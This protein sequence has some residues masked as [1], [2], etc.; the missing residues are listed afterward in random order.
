M[1][2]ITT[3]KRVEVLAPT[4][5]NH[6][7]LAVPES[8]TDIRP[9]IAADVLP[10]EAADAVKEASFRGE[11][12]AIQGIATALYG[13]HALREAGLS[14]FDARRILGEAHEASRSRLRGQLLRFLGPR[15]LEAMPDKLPAIDYVMFY[16]V[17]LNKRVSWTL[18][19]L[20]QTGVVYAQVT[21]DQ[22]AA[23]GLQVAT[24]LAQSGRTVTGAP[25][26][27]APAPD[28]FDEGEVLAN[29]Y[30]PKLTGR[31]G[32]KWIAEL[33]ATVDEVRATVRRMDDGE[34][35]LAKVENLVKR[36]LTDLVADRN[37][38]RLEALAG[39]TAAKIGLTILVSARAIITVAQIN[40][41]FDKF[42]EVG[43]LI[44]VGRAK[45]ADQIDK[46]GSSVFRHPRTAT[47]AET[48]ANACAAI[49]P[50][51]SDEEA[52][53][54]AYEA[55]EAAVAKIAEE[56]AALEAQVLADRLEGEARRRSFIEAHKRVM[57]G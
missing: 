19:K 43:G 8:K 26:A 2:D 25:A 38:A 44:T 35:P 23:R 46:I 54:V 57:G 17:E 20:Q 45:L 11:R 56:V 16:S 41:L 7:A 14:Q 49:K 22:L 30:G 29:R 39:G 13:L 37:K 21:A 15:G 51:H 55:F 47:I 12:T 5:V 48:W 9:W 40:A 52:L 50:E 42:G 27:P 24:S 33:G 6:A 4:I 10:P 18:Q 3:Q 32:N 36:A 34:R 31:D 53:R 1:S 28:R